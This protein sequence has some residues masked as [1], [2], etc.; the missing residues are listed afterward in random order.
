MIFVGMLSHAKS[1]EERRKKEEGR[2]E[3]KNRRYNAYKLSFLIVC[4]RTY[5]KKPGFL[6]K[7][8]I[9]NKVSRKKP[10]F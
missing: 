4:I 10:G 9:L 8:K 1:S 5:A 2:R 6:E 7:S 3:V